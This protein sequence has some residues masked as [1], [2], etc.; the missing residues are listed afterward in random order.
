MIP[1][2]KQNIDKNDI[3]SVI[4]VMQSDYLTQGP[5]T[6]KFEK[7][8]SA[9][10]GAKYAVAVVNATSALHLSCLALGVGKGDIVWTSPISFVA[11]ANCAKYCDAEVDFVDI[12]METYN[13][14]IEALQI[15][16]SN[17]S[18]T[19]KLPKVLIPVHLAGRS[20][21]MK[22]IKE[23]S[24]EY[25]FKIIEDASHAIGGKYNGEA[26]GNCNYSDITVFSFHPV[27]I[28]T[29]CEGG[30]CMTNDSNIYDKIYRLRSHG[31]VR[32]E[33]QMV[34][35]SHGSW[36]YEQIDLGFNFRLNDLQS[37]LGINQLKRI[38]SFV[39]F[40]HK[41]A[42]KYDELFKGS[43]NIITPSQ[44]INE[45]SSFHLYIIRVIN[46]DGVDRKVI[47]E[48]LRNEG[49]YVNIHYIPIY[50]Q[51]YFSNEFDV[52]DFPN[53]EKYYSEAISLPIY[54]NLKEEH[55]K[56]VVD[57]VNK[58]ANFQNIF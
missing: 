37:A 32:S 53:S 41:I 22:K 24:I 27:K 28:I 46:E 2:G 1:Y 5:I 33:E 43:S 6:P 12:D 34:N 52:K 54:P 50:R 21:D 9:Y 23:L 4:E 51:P 3:S 10:C 18:K 44:N 38:D 15:K 16:L 57:I 39:N 42:R 31:I 48:K 20:C 29:T 11:S 36:Y 49:V 40:R 45:Y 35:K 7:E 26:I 14:S 47:F 55:I 30:V 13:I 8:L 19:G 58:P 56:Q 17:A 25:G